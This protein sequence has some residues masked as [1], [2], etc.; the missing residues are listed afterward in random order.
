MIHIRNIE[1]TIRGR[2]Q[3]H[4]PEARVG[5]GQ[6]FLVC[7]DVFPEGNPLFPPDLDRLDEMHSGIGNSCW[8]PLS[9]KS[10]SVVPLPVFARHN[11]EYLGSAIAQYLEIKAR[12]PDALLLY[13]MGDFYETFFDDAEVLARVAG[14]TLTSRDKDSDHPVPLAGVPYHAIDTYL[15]RLI[16]AGLTVAICEQVEDPAAAKGLVK[17]DVVEIISP[18]TVT[19]PELVSGAGGRYCLAYLATKDTTGGDG[20]ALVDATTGEFR[21][22]QESTTLASLCEKHGVREAIVP[23]AT[24]EATLRRWRAA[25]P[26]LVTNRVSDTWFHPAFARR[27]LLE[28]WRQFLAALVQAQINCSRLGALAGEELL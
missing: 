16:E 3:I 25:L 23:E 6:N 24:D 11:E 8:T 9:G 10:D 2:L 12:H 13:R 14:V 5:A 18:G 17:R 7:I 26:N 21:C 4:R 22:G 15:T 1:G 28:T 19:A 27:T 20:W